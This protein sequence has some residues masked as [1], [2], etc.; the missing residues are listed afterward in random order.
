MIYRKNIND[1]KIVFKLIAV[2]F[3]FFGVLFLGIGLGFNAY[4]SRLEKKC[5]DKTTATVVDIKS[6]QTS[7]RKNG[8]HTVET[9]TYAP[10]V[11]Y[12][13]DGKKFKKSSN[14]YSSNND[15]YIG[16]EIEIYYDPND[17]QQVYIKDENASEIFVLVFSLIGG[18]FF[19]IGVAFAIFI[20]KNKHSHQSNN[21]DFIHQQI[22]FEN[23]HKEG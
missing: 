9:V 23:N 11:E 1:P 15:N 22:N 17:P 10:V 7:R 8:H 4:N 21:N 12:T 5:T 20:V 18:V 6:Q 14:I 2:I 19:I 16:E 3:I 13:V